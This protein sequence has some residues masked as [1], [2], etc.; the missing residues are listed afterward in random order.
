MITVVDA[1]RH[2]PKQ[3]CIRSSLDPEDPFAFWESDESDESEH[4]VPRRG[5]DTI[6]TILEPNKPSTVISYAK[7]AVSFAADATK[8]AV[9]SSADV[10]K[11]AVPSS[12]DVTTKSTNK[13]ADV[14][15]SV[16]VTKAAVSTPVPS[17]LPVQ[18][19]VL[20][21]GSLRKRK[22]APKVLK[23]K[24]TAED[25]LQKIFDGGAGGA[26]Q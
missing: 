14:L 22:S 2:T 12:A 24:M 19:D 1:L 20:D 16:D 9:P 10:T 11:A 23:E 21:A 26:A 17:L 4:G 25:M 15:S 6:L 7:F 18:D 13:K 3:A 5:N 8:A